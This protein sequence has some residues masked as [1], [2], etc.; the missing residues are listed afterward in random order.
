MTRVLREGQM[1][2]DKWK[3]HLSQISQRPE[4]TRAKKSNISSANNTNGFIHFFRGI[5]P[6]QDTEILPI[7]VKQK[8]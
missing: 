8:F 3:C 1:E 4:N 7:D 5:K 2:N 6:T